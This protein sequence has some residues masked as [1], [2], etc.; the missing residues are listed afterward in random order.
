M[1]IFRIRADDDLLLAALV[2]DHDDLAIDARHDAVGRAVGHGR[3]GAIP[4]PEAL[5]GA[6]LRFGKDRH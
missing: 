4:R 1:R 3:A 2:F 6:A 5:A